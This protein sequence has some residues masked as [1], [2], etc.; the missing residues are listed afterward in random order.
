MLEELIIRY[1]P[2]PIHLLE[3]MG[4]TVI[5]IGAFKAFYQ[6]VKSLLLKEHYPVK[7]QF[8]EAMA[9]A[10]EFKLAAEILKTVLV[11]SL[12]EIAILGAIVLLR[13]LITLIIYWEIKQDNVENAPEH[14]SKQKT[15]LDGQFFTF[16]Y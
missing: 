3:L 6:Y 5:T 8:A 15:D 2:L 12:Q 4:I 14:N 16:I 7:Y 1:L 9:M 10:L 13:I 11:R